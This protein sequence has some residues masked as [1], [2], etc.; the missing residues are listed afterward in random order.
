MLEAEGTAC[1]KLLGQEDR[2]TGGWGREKQAS[3]LFSA[4]S[5]IC[6]GVASSPHLSEIS[7]PPQAPTCVTH[8]DSVDLVYSPSQTTSTL[9]RLVVVHTLRRPDRTQTP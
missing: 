1:A 2:A 3:A 7:F 6:R 4:G 8:K 9:R 5:D